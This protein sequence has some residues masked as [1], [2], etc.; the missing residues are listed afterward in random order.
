[1]YIFN[2]HSPDSHFSAN[3]F[4]EVIGALIQSARLEL[5]LDLMF[6]YISPPAAWLNPPSSSVS[7]SISSVSTLF[8]CSWLSDGALPWYSGEAGGWGGH[9]DTVKALV[10]GRLEWKNQR[11]WR[12]DN[13]VGRIVSSEFRAAAHDA[14]AG[15]AAATRTNVSHSIH[16]GPEIIFY[17]PGNCIVVSDW[18]RWQQSPAVL[19]FG[20]FGKTMGNIST[21]TISY[22]FI[23]VI[24]L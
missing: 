11:S 23:S 15:W 3:S 16:C 7:P 1:M 17:F 2:V 24:L 14:A 9:G 19:L 10:G 22:N 20:F 21:G 5:K 12:P 8:A 6:F 4:D 18:R 13:W